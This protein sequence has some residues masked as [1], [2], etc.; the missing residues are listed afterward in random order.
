M[1]THTPRFVKMMVLC[2]CVCVHVCVCVYVCVR[3]CMCACVCVRAC[4]RVHVCVRVCVRVRV[5]VCVCVEGE[6]GRWCQK[7]PWRER[8]ERREEGRRGERG[9]RRTLCCVYAHTLQMIVSTH[10]I[11]DISYCSQDIEDKR[12]FAY[13]TKDKSGMNY[14]HVFIAASEVST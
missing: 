3:V 6:E 10:V 2:A 4:V 14:C 7:W 8:K 11:R 1:W 9:R 12:V 13:I 5:R